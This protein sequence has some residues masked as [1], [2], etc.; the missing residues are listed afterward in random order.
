MIQTRIPRIG[1]RRPKESRPISS[2]LLRTQ[3]CDCRGRIRARRGGISCDVFS[4]GKHLVFSLAPASQR[5]RF[6]HFFT[7]LIR[8][9]G[10][11]GLLSAWFGEYPPCVDPS[12]P[13]AIPPVCS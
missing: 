6:L 9:P 1:W 10:E 11:S 3:V 5:R 12:L 4:V 13:S 7:I 2:V 8:I